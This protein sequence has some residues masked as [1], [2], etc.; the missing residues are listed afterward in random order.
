MILY[1]LK[2]IKLFKKYIDLKNGIF[3][4]RSKEISVGQVKKRRSKH[5]TDL[6]RTYSNQKEERCSQ[7]TESFGG[8]FASETDL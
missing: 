5:L 4:T 1:S 6:E 3:Y 8:W 2:N 7:W